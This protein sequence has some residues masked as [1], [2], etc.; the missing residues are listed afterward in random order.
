MIVQSVMCFLACRGNSKFVMYLLLWMSL[1]EAVRLE[2]KH[3]KRFGGRGILLAVCSSLKTKNGVEIEGSCF[4]YPIACPLLRVCERSS[5]LDSL[6]MTIAAVQ[7]DSWDFSAFV[8]SIAY[9]GA[10]SAP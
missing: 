8:H 4:G 3:P 7:Y 6:R 5:S 10:H 2:A 1:K 9:F